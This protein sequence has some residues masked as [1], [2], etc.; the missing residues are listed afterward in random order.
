ML[1]NLLD[2]DESNTFLVKIGLLD[3][4]SSQAPTLLNGPK[5][6]APMPPALR[7]CL[8]LWNFC[9][10]AYCLIY[11]F[12]RQLFWNKLDVQFCVANVISFLYN[13]ELLKWS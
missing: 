6:S 1:Q 8:R 5:P 11:F 12:W 13:K 10:K 7:F 3:L 9:N 4:S 2:L